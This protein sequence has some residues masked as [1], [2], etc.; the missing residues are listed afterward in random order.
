MKK[1]GGTKL[2]PRN[3]SIQSSTNN[4]KE[5]YNS[6]KK[7][8]PTLIYSY[9]RFTII[10]RMEENKDEDTLEQTKEDKTT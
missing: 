2:E 4:L 6:N 1:G 5:P 3:T 7:V 10:S 9:N 8:D